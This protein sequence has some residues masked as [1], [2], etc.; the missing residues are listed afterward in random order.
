MKF[1]T[2]EPYLDS[3]EEE[4]IKYLDEADQFHLSF[5]GWYQKNINEL[6]QVNYLIIF[7][8]LYNQITNM[9][10]Y[11]PNTLKEFLNSFKKCDTYFYSLNQQTKR[12]D[13]HLLLCSRKI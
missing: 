12:T 6:K 10:F 7:Q 9:E 5:Q 4:R 3:D 11:G 13:R 1:L 2:C 8:N